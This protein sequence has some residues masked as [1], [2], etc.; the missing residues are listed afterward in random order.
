MQK[1]LF[2]SENTSFILPMNNLYIA[3]VAFPR[4]ANVTEAANRIALWHE[5]DGMMNRAGLHARVQELLAK[6]GRVSPAQMI[7]SI[8]YQLEADGLTRIGVEEQPVYVQGADGRWSATSGPIVSVPLGTYLPDSFLKLH[9]RIMHDEQTDRICFAC[10]PPYDAV[11]TD[12]Y[13]TA[14]APRTVRLGVFTGFA[15][16]RR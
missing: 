8:A 6:T 13:V 5:G 11:I 12:G 16:F 9:P 3:L 4:R 1:K 7:D 15:A 14:A 2:Y 10:D